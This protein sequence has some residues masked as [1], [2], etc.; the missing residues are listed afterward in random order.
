V[1][2]M[3]LL[4]LLFCFVSFAPLAQANAAPPAADTSW[5]MASENPTG[6]WLLPSHD[7]VIQIVPCGADLCGQIVGMVLQPT[8]PV[9][10]DWAGASQCGLTIIRTAPAVDGNGRVVWR[11]TIVNPRDG[12]AYHAQITMGADHA[13][14]LRGYVGLPIFGRTQTWKSYHGP[15]ASS[16]CRLNQISSS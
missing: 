5:K 1:R 11:G 6:R 16:D 13:L 7:A 2:R 3:G 15:D 9:P 10:K 12:S 14:K 8:E 4:A